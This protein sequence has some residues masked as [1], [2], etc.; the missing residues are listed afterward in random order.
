MQII[1]SHPKPTELDIPSVIGQCVAEPAFQVMGIGNSH[2]ECESLICEREMTCSLFSECI[3]IFLSVVD[4]LYT[5]KSWKHTFV[6]ISEFSCEGERRAIVRPL[7]LKG[8]LELQSPL[9][10][11]STFVPHS[12]LYSV[13]A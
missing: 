6:H 11:Q 7:G 2:K 5:L 1:W 8:V 4:L 13:G 12:I 3:E 9:C 10:L